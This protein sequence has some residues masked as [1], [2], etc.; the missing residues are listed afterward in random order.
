[1]DATIL[2]N[3]V[4]D[5]IQKYYKP[6]NFSIK[7]TDSNLSDYHI[8]KEELNKLNYITDYDP[9]TNT[10]V[11]KAI[12]N[13]NA[14]GLNI[15]KI[16]LRNITD[17]TITIRCP[18]HKLYY[19]KTLKHAIYTYITLDQHSFRKELEELLIYGGFINNYDAI[20]ELR[21]KTLIKNT[22]L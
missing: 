1:M 9:D 17:N 12:I 22:T 11:Y 5:V 18:R 13:T 21:Q 8:N 14:L 6:V 15:K 10:T 3:I 4:V 19:L 20:I 2:Y 16:L 7:L